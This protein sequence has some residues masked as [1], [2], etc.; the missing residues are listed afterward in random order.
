MCKVKNVKTVF[1]W[2][3]YFI[4][5]NFVEGVSIMFCKNCGAKLEE[6]TKFCSSC[7]KQ[8]EVNTTEIKE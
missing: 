6:G 1:S 2:H 5:Y 4:W 3:F 8:V 7:G